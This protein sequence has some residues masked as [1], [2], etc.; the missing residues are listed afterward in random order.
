MHNTYTHQYARVHIHKYYAQIKN[1]SP[2]MNYIHVC[3]A[4]LSIYGKK[5]TINIKVYVINDIVAINKELLILRSN[6]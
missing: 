2:I 5:N 4:L 1:N 6:I 3:H